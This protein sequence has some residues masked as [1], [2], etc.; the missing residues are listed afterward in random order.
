[1]DNKDI[2][3]SYHENG[4]V[5]LKSNFSREE[6][7]NLKNYLDSMPPKVFIPFTEIPWGW[8]N[9]V[10]DNNLGFIVNNKATNEVLSKVLGNYV[11]NHLYVHNKVRWYGLLENWHQEVYNIKTFAPGFNKE[12]WDCFAQ[13]YVPLDPQNLENGCL[14]IIPQSHKMGVLEHIDFIGPNMGHKR[15]TTYTDVERAYQK[16]GILNLELEPGDVVIFNHLLLHGSTSNNG[17]FDRRAIVLQA[18]SDIKKKSDIEFEEETA[19]RT[20]YTVGVLR[21]ELEKQ[22]AKRA[23]YSDS[24]REGR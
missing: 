3:K 14:K 20:N 9:L 19:Y 17:P 10:D 13:V 18:R 6:C 23:L 12:D 1:M 15:I 11:Y 24:H 5:I 7:N 16:Y 4:Y 2:I 22:E 8:G 21:A